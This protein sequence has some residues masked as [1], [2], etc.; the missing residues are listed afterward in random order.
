[1]HRVEKVAY[2]E[3]FEEVPQGVHARVLSRLEVTHE[4]SG[5]LTPL[6]TSKEDE[7]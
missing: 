2:L 4:K 3:V 5:E 7:G 1:V 6:S